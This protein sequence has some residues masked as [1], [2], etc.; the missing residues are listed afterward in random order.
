MDPPRIVELGEV[1]LVRSNHSTYLGEETENFLGE[2]L[3][4]NS[5]GPC[6]NP[7]VST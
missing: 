5:G 3:Y 2:P 1:D 4:A 6:A 7:Y